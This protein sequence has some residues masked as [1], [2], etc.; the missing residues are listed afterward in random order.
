MQKSLDNLKH[1]QVGLVLTLISKIKESGIQDDITITSTLKRTIDELIQR[2][3]I[4]PNPDIDEQ[5]ESKETLPEDSFE[6][7]LKTMLQQMKKQL[8]TKHK[9]MIDTC[10]HILTPKTDEIKAAELVD[11]KELTENLRVFTEQKNLY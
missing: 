11:K 4:T 5:E 2:F 1:A 3:V 8:I 9:S 10:E 6:P 7:I